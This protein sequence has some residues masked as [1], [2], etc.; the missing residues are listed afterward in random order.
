MWSAQQQVVSPLSPPR[1][2]GL[3]SA[4]GLSDQKFLMLN[5][6]IFRMGVQ[7]I[8]LEAGSTQQ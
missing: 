8:P 5:F 3:Q 1:E 4:D 7:S 6:R 2:S